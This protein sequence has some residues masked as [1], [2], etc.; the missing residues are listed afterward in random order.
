MEEE[1]EQEEPSEGEVDMDSNPEMMEMM[2][3]LYRDMHFSIAVEV[4][5]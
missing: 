3:E 4:N 2:R 5:G 1:M